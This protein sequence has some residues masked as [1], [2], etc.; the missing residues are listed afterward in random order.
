MKQLQRNSQSM[1]FD[2][3]VGLECLPE[4]WTSVQTRKD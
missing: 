3:Q 1:A 4:R 2:V